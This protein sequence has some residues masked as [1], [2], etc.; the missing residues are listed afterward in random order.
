MKSWRLNWALAEVSES[1]NFARHRRAL[2]GAWKF[3]A[4]MVLKFVPH[5]WPFTIR[6][7]LSQG[8][9]IAVDQFMTLF[10]YKEIFVDGCYDLELPENH[11]PLIVDVG[12]NTGLFILRMKQLYPQAHVYAFEPLPTNYAQLQTNLRLSELDRVRT[13]MQGV[14]GTARKETLYIHPRNVGGHSI[15]QNQTGGKQ[16]VEI[17]LIDIEALLRLL[18]GKSCDL[19]KLDCEGA[20]YEII[21]SISSETAQRFERILF[22]ATPSLYDVEELTQHLENVGYRI[23]RHKGLHMAVKYH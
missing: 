10:I 20:E 14:G 19:L 6:L 2:R 11:E 7:N 8:G 23:E 12:A 16:R 13:F 21:K 4:A 9:V 15:F 22:E 1:S 17:E 5:V 3:W 18:D